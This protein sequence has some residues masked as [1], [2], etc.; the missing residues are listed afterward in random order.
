M[1]AHFTERW[2]DRL[3]DLEKSEDILEKLYDYCQNCTVDTAVCLHILPQSKGDFYSSN[4]NEIWAIIR[5]SKVITVMFR[6]S[7]QPKDRYSFSVDKVFAKPL[8]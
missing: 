1:T 6:R 8:V 2:S 7:N 3:S 5:N 4:G